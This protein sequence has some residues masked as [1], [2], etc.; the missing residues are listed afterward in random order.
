VGRGCRLLTVA[1]WQALAAAGRW[2]LLR[3]IALDQ[4]DCARHQEDPMRIEASSA[5]ALAPHVWR[6]PHID[7]AR[8]WADHASGRIVIETAFLDR[9]EALRAALG[10][11]PLPITSGYRTPDHNQAVSTTGPEGPHTTARAVDIGIYGERAVAL[12]RAALELGFTGI[13][14]KQTGPIDGRFI[15]LD[16]LPPGHPA[17]PRPWIWSYA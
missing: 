4:W 8:E 1:E 9:F 3:A 14:I 6:W 2:G 10:G 12:V 17:I 11:H 16:D 15:H 5:A 7:P 13:G